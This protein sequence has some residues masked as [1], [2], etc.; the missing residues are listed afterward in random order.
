MPDELLRD[1][2]QESFGEK[3]KGYGEDRYGI[4]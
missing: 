2:L 4:G 3:E 1:E